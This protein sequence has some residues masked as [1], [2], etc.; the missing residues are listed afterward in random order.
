MLV[1][2]S[3]STQRALLLE[4]AE[5]K[6]Q[7]AQDTDRK[8]RALYIQD[9]WNITDNLNLSASGTYVRAK[10]TTDFCR[11]IFVDGAP[12]IDLSARALNS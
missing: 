5:L 11:Y 3:S 10:L 9:S 4:I 6:R 2:E 7:L 12:V 8:Q 1:Q